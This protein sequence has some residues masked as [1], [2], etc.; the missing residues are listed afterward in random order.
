MPL[1]SYI[2]RGF[3][4]NRWWRHYTI[5]HKMGGGIKNTVHSYVY[6]RSF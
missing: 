1:G 4:V 3:N 6:E 2:A 5:A